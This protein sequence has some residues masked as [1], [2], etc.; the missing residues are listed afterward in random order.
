MWV[1]DFLIDLGQILAFRE[2]W[3]A[4][5]Y[6]ERS[7]YNI[8]APT[9]S[10]RLMVPW[11]LWLNGVLRGARAFT[12]GHVI[13]YSGTQLRQLEDRSERDRVVADAIATFFSA[14]E[15][16]AVD[17]LRPRN[18]ALLLTGT[19]SPAVPSD[20]TGVAVT[21]PAVVPLANLLVAGDAVAVRVTGAATDELRTVSSVGATL[22]VNRDL[23]AD[24]AGHVVEIRRLDPGI[25]R[26]TSGDD[27]LARTIALIRGSSAHVARQ[28]PDDYFDSG[29]VQVEEFLPATSRRSTRA[30]IAA[31]QLLVTFSKGDPL[32]PYAV[33]DV[34]RLLSGG[35]YFARLVTGTRPAASIVIDTPLPAGVHTGMQVARLL[36]GGVVAN[37]QAVDGARLGVAGL[38]TLAAREGLL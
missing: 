3:D 26:I 11:A 27:S 32:A 21:T 33:G 38:A 5:G 4:D 8:P 37:N 16:A 12:L 1:V 28:V 31:E 2:V 17:V 24:F 19:A 10:Y 35:T 34:V 36:P 6:W 15:A 9:A 14:T 18:P 30:T 23:P 22:T 29:D 13:W 7:V 25:V 20:I